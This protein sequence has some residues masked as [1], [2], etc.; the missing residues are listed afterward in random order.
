MITAEDLKK[1]VLFQYLKDTMLEKIAP[2]AVVM[3]YKPNNYVFQEGNNADRIYS[4]VEGNVV[5]EIRK[6]SGN[7]VIINTITPGMTIGISAVIDTPE[8][9]YMTSARA[10]TETKAYSWKSDELECLFSQDC[11]MGLLFMK[12]IAKILKTRLEVRNIQFIDIYK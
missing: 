3:E 1:I 12:R 8:R 9:K 6:H 2:L 7:D 11:E 4:I 10:Y 5:L